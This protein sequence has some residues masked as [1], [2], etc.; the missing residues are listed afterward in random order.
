MRGRWC[1]CS[2]LT[3]ASQVDFLGQNVHGKDGGGGGVRSFVK[4]KGVEREET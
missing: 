2:V 4:G 3:F 1:R